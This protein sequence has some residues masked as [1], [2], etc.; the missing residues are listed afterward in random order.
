M[1]GVKLHAAR[2]VLGLD[3]RG[4]R[5][6][7][8][9]TAQGPVPA[10]RFLI[11]A[12]A[13]SPLVLSAVGWRPEIR[14][15]RGQIALLRTSGALFR[16]ILLQGKRYLVPRPDCRVL[17]GST[18]EDVGFDRRTTAVAISDLL[19]FAGTLVPALA[20]AEV[21]RCWSG[22]RPGSPDGLPYIGLV[23]GWSNLFVAAGHFR[24]GIELSPA[25]GLVLKDLLA[26][27][28][29]CMSLEPFRPDRVATSG[30]VPVPHPVR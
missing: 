10:G 22:L 28:E 5:V 7:T 9:Q 21:E 29:P 13:W 15:I 20:V 30:E 19:Q 1:R 16:R 25:T 12:G 18:E 27:R 4:D 24:A 8:A 23:P 26:G 17:A 14:P 6:V 2:P 11:A 3:R